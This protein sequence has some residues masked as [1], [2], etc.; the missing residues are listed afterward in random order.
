MERPGGCAGCWRRRIPRSARLPCLRSPA[1][2][3]R[4]AV[5]AG[6]LQLQVPP[7]ARVGTRHKFTRT[8]LCACSVSACATLLQGALASDKGGGLWCCNSHVPPEESLVCFCTLYASATLLACALV[9]FQSPV[10]LRRWT[11]PRA[12]GQTAATR[13]PTGLWSA[14]LRASCCRYAVPWLTQGL[15]L[16]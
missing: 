4:A 14:S 6:V 3:R 8:F 2:Y 16:R 13:A 5:L 7:K 10:V 12:A 15:D 9:C 11:M 1:S